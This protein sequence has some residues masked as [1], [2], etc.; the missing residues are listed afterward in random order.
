T[1]SHTT[2]EL[3]KD[4]IAIEQSLATVSEIRTSLR[5][6]T[7]LIQEDRKGPHFVQN[8]SH[9]LNAVKRELNKLST[10]S[11]RLRGNTD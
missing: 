10:E 6:F 1:M 7:R 5:Y 8:F 4:I 11:D 9:R 2:A 3:E